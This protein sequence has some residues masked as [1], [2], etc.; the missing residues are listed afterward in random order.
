MLDPRLQSRLRVLA[1]AALI[2]LAPT[3]AWASS[4][5]DQQCR[6][7]FNKSDAG[8]TSG[9]NICWWQ[10]GS[11]SGGNCTITTKCYVGTSY[12]LSTVTV[13][14]TQVNQLQNC[15]GYIALSC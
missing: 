14:W 13:G 3:A 5:W 4:A 9:A 11:W 2:V 7:E 6:T 15:T 8:R 12:S 1:A 10:S